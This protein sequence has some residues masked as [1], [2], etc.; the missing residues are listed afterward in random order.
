MKDIKDR[1][2]KVEE[3]MEEKKRLDAKE[4]QLKQESRKLKMMDKIE[5]YNRKMRQLVL[6]PLNFTPGISPEHHSCQGEG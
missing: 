2:K 1:F 5:N 3:N 4:L 6:S